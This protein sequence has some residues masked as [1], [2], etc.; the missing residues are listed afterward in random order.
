M[1]HEAQQRESRQNNNPHREHTRQKD[2]YQNR[3]TERKSHRELMA[4]I[5]RESTTD[6]N[7]AKAKTMKGTNHPQLQQKT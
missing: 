6:I 3:V 4:N 1:K 7:E 5:V 2:K